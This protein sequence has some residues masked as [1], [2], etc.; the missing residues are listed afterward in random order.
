MA[1]PATRRMTLDESLAWDDGTDRRYELW[2]GA[3]TAIAPP[4][5]RHGRL[6]WR[7]VEKSAPR[8][9]GPVAKHRGFTLEMRR[10]PLPEPPVPAIG[11]S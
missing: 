8:C 11:M 6:L 7:S 4:M 2:G 1:E 9:R 10:I 3:V 5:P